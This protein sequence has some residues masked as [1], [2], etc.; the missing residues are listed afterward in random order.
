MNIW[1]SLL[2]RDIIQNEIEP[3]YPRIIVLLNEELDTAKVSINHCSF[4][5]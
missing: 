5:A 2:K 3:E 1:D 4:E